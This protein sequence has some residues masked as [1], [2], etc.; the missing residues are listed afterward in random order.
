M[1]LIHNIDYEKYQA[2]AVEGSPLRQP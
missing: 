1:L 2:K